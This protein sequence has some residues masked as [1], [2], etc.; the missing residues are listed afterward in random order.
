MI[1]HWATTLLERWRLTGGIRNDCN[2]FFSF[3]TEAILKWQLP[4]QALQFPKTTVKNHWFIM[5]LT[6]KLNQRASEISSHPCTNQPGDAVITERQMW[7]CMPMSVC[8]AS[9]YW[10][11]W[12]M[13]TLWNECPPKLPFVNSLAQVSPRQCLT[14][15]GNVVAPEEWI[16]F[17]VALLLPEILW[18]FLFQGYFFPSVALPESRAPPEEAVEQLKSLHRSKSPRLGEFFGDSWRK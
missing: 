18:T 13:V 1:W 5:N 8:C 3:K 6:F 9:N 15:E 11:L 4:D 16:E 10:Y 2:I 7:G 12:V 14:T 17:S